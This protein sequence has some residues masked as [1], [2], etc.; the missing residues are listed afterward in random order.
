MLDAMDA[1]KMRDMVVMAP[2]HECGLGGRAW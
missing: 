2:H 1:M